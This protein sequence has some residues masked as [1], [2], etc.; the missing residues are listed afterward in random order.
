[1]GD[2]HSLYNLLLNT[3]LLKCLLNFTDIWCVTQFYTK[4][5]FEKISGE[6]IL[7]LLYKK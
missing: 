5:L 3:L 2:S 1:M 7:I 4:Y 6:M